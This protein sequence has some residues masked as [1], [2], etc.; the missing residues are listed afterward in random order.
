MRAVLG[1]FSGPMTISATTAIIT[2]SE[3]P[4]SNMGCGDTARREAQAA[5]AGRDENG[6]KAAARALHLVGRI[7]AHFAFDRLA[8]S[9]RR[10]GRRGRGLILGLHALL[11]AFDRAAQILT[12]VAELLGAE[13]QHD[14]Q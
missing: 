8:E 7:L 9:L 4:T 3:N 6:V 2:I 1:S 14:D 10:L 5:H 11:E 13:N 12:H